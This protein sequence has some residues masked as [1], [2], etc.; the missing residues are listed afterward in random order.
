MASV[1]TR[2]TANGRDNDR[3]ARAKGRPPGIRRALTAMSN[4]QRVAYPMGRTKATG[5]I[6]V[7]GRARVVLRAA[8][9][10]RGGFKVVRER[11]DRAIRRAAPAA[12]TIRVVEGE[13]G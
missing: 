7:P 11:P 6:V 8:L 13:G 9:D 4:R 2:A 5:S 1:T 10:S 3:A 12:P